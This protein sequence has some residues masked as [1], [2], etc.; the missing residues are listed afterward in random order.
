LH[1]AGQ[2]RI[3]YIVRHSRKSFVGR[4]I[5]WE[6]HSRLFRFHKIDKE[7]TLHHWSKLQLG[8]CL[9]LECIHCWYSRPN[10]MG[11]ESREERIVRW[12]RKNLLNIL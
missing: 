7:C 4:R 6:Y 9:K 11:I 5:D 3:W 8:K 12:I 1:K 10:L 2:W